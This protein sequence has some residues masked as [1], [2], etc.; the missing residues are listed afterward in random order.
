MLELHT[1]I[2]NY[3]LERRYSHQL[4]QNVTNTILFKDAD[5][6]R[7]HRTRVIHIEKHG[8]FTLLVTFQALGIH[9]RVCPGHISNWIGFKG[10]Q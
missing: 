4:W 5:N 2:L 10:E 8:H 1:Q 7:I 3:A 6:V 9:Y